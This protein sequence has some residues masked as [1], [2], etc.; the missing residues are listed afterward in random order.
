[1]RGLTARTVR[2]YG[3]HPVHLLTLIASFALV[4]YVV[5][6]LGPS[7]WLGSHVWWKSIPVWFVGSVLLHDVVLFPLYAVADRSV[8]AGWRAVTGRLP[9][10]RAR[11]SPVNY[12]RIPAMASGLLLAVYL[13]GII[14]QGKGTFLR[15]T[16]LTQE[17]YLDRWLIITAVLFGASAVAYAVRV[18]LVRRASVGR[19]RRAHI[20]ERDR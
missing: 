2:Y 5:S 13:P 3:A 1:M 15:A 8:G 12:L 17:P 6:V 18:G 9:G 14:R 19:R 20:H 10:G 11:V 16:G 4:G 7:R